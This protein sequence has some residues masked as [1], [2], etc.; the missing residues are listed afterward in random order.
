MWN[1]ESKCAK[2]MSPEVLVNHDKYLTDG[3]I[4]GMRA[5]IHLGFGRLT[6]DF[7]SLW[8]LF[9]QPSQDFFYE[10]CVRHSYY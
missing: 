2:H 10:F 7:L 4:L 9:L 1:F 8:R 5:P 6:R 3:S